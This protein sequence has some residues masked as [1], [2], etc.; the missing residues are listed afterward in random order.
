MIE[1]ELKSK[2]PEKLDPKQF[3][4]IPGSRRTY[5]LISMIHIWLAAQGGTGSKVRVLVALLDYR[6][7]FDL[8]DLNLLISKL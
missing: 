6:K 1:Y 7:A 2:L 3:G 5:A 4:F 8:A